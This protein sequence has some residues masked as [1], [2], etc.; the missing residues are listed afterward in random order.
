MALVGALCG[1]G[2][3]AHAQSNSIVVWNDDFDQQP[4]GASSTNGAPFTEGAVA[5]NFSGTGIGNPQITVI[6]NDPDSLGTETNEAAFTF[7]TT[8]ATQGTALN[9][10]LEIN[11]LPA[12]GNTDP[13]LADYWLEFDV[14]LPTNS[15]AIGSLGPTGFGY[16]DVLGLYG[17]YGGEYYGDGCQ[18][19]EP[20]SFYPNPGTGYQHVAL[21]LGT[22]G[23]AGATLLPPTDNPL[24]F[25][26][27][28]FLSA[29]TNANA[30]EEI[31]IANIQV[32][33]VTNVPPPPPPTM[34]IVKAY[35]GLR[36]F[37]KNNQFTYN[38]EGFGTLDN[39]QS[40]V[41]STPGNPPTY[42]ATIGDFNTVNGFTFTTTF[43]PINYSIDPD[44]VYAAYYCTNTFT[45]TITKQDT[46]FTGSLDWKT[47]GY[48]NNSSGTYVNALL[49][50]NTVG[51]GTWTLKFTDDTDGTLTPPGGS[52]VAFTLPPAVAAT[53]ANPV[54]IMWN[55]APNSTGGYG[56]YI[57]IDSVNITN[58][59]GANEFDDFTKDAYDPANPQSIG[60]ES[61]GYWVSSAYSVDVN[62][63]VQVGTNT[64]YWV[65][66]TEPP[67]NIW[68][69]L[70]DT[71]LTDG[72]T[73]WFTPGYYNNY[74][75]VTS[76]L[77][78]N[79][80]VWT[81]ISTGNL[82][83]VDGNPGDAI[84]PSGFFELTTN[85]P[86]Q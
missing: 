69:L 27:G 72:Y 44:T 68:N 36:I 21:N 13:N 32:V 64:P 18:I 49:V 8:P 3:A 11:W 48:I 63:D 55:I 24:N 66:W 75:P 78:G 45:L 74:T 70:T 82:P 23:S 25:H 83:T 10:G 35:S 73:N 2:T 61:L 51:V 54:N 4:V 81:L 12:T 14:A 80:P 29:L 65:T 47:N 59:A 43:V 39:N 57:D 33:M 34:N 60:N 37:A 28:F 1:F 67:A 6:S 56:Q 58:V 84:S 17:N 19:S 77:M 38:G 20:Q 40:W 7:D 15:T 52:P 16:S 31:D 85:T 5:Y 42:S 46:Y 22:F 26:L 71:N 53:L 76:T 9:F 86:T 30:N 41:G 79:G 50:T 62:S